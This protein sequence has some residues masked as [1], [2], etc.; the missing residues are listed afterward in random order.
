M[1]HRATPHLSKYV[2]HWS[3]YFMNPLPPPPL[4]T[5]IVVNKD[6]GSSKHPTACRSFNYNR[7][8]QALVCRQVSNLCCPRDLR[9]IGEQSGLNVSNHEKTVQISTWAVNKMLEFRNVVVRS[10]VVANFSNVNVHHL[11]CY[12]FQNKQKFYFQNK[13]PWGRGY[14]GVT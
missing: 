14:T 1:S 5:F 11:L 3:K 10:F 4:G 8:N 9:W 12:I 2:C 13:I 7:N 6:H